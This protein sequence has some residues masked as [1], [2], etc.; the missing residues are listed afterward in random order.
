MT[1][2]RG[3]GRPRKNPAEPTRSIP[4]ATSATDA[5]RRLEALKIERA[6]GTRQVGLFESEADGS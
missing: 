6:T 2:R 3:P 4:E 5:I 1:A